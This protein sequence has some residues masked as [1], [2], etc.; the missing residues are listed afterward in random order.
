MPL[1]SWIK[2]FRLS[3]EQF[4]QLGGILTERIRDLEDI[5]R[6][7]FRNIRRYES[8]YQAEPK[9]QRKT[10]PWDGA[11]NIVAPVIMTSVD[12]ST[13]R[14][15]SLIQSQR[16]TIWTGHSHNIDFQK[17]YLA[18][19]LGFLNW[20][21]R[22]EFD[23]FWCVLDWIHEN[24]KIGGSVLAVTWE[25]E[26]RYL[27]LPRG[28]KPQ[29]VVTHRGPKWVHWPAE[30]ILWEPGQS[31]R[32]ADEV[33]T[34]SLVSWGELVRLAQTETG[35]REEAVKETKNHPHLHGSPGAEIQAFKEQRAGV[36]P[37]LN[38]SRRHTFDKRTA[39][40]DWPQLQRLGVRGLEDATTIRD[41]VSGKLVRVPIIVEFDPDSKQ[42]F[43][44]MPNPYITADGNPFF[45]IY[46]KKQ[47]GYPRGVGLCKI[48]EGMQRGI[49]TM[50]NQAID[51]VTLA[52]SMPYMTTDSKLQQKPITPGLGVLVDTMDSIK[53]IEGQKGVMPEIALLQ[54]L[55]TYHER[56]SGVNDPLLGRESRSGGHPSPATNYLGQLQ[57]SAEMGSLPVRMIRERLSKAGEYTASLYQLFD[58]RPDGRIERVFGSEETA[59]IKS[60]LFPMDQTI[61]GNIEFDMYA[62]SETESPQVQ[63]QQAIQ[64][65]QVTN[66][67]SAA[68][69]RLLQA[70]ESPQAG[71]LTKQ[72]CI[73][74]IETLG[75]TYQQ[76]LEASDFEEARD[77]ILDLEAKNGQNGAA[78]QGLIQQFQGL[79][80]QGAPPQQLGP[81]GPPPGGAGS[82]GLFPVGPLAGG[83][84]PLAGPGVPSPAGGQPQ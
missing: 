30:K 44:A 79:A 60:W 84:S 6:V 70:I 3:D 63:Q 5:H 71:P 48:G 57:Q 31:V 39:W 10:F 7:F 50:F 80:Q 17:R 14:Q 58:T 83:G 66:A 52:N 54:A 22:N 12:A 64:T 61:P 42:V 82:A 38:V 65:F 74:T 62:L 68:A 35:Y 67:Y 1:P 56:A 55:Q 29:R 81:G 26:E 43:R 18:D 13:S 59:T 73:Q 28:G 8:W 40:L 53:I 15:F 51:A 72:A 23:T 4:V 33:Y 2:P 34:Q 25:E 37:D 69:L 21:A 24:N 9:T 11:S 49:S 47:T 77:M 19:I 78:L 46:F 16:R 36:D 20:S 32:E 76:F 45:D 75:R 27:M 41:E